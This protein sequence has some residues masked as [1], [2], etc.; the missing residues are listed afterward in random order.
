VLKLSTTQT[1]HAY[2]VPAIV[3][4]PHAAG[5]P[6]AQPLGPPLPDRPPLDQLIDRLAQ[7]GAINT[8][9]SNQ[10]LCR[11]LSAA[12][13]RP[14]EHIIVNSIESQPPLAA[15]RAQLAEQPQAVLDAAQMLFD[16][17]GAR[18]LWLTVQS[19]AAS[20]L[21]RL[22]PLC[23]RRPV[24]L[25]PLPPKY[26]QEC[27]ILLT[28]STIGLT[29][30]ADRRAIES[31]ILILDV[32]TALAVHRAA[33]LALPDTER[34]ITIAGDAARSPGCYRIPTGISLADLINRVG[35]QGSLHRVVV[36]SPMTGQSVTDLSTVVSRT[37]AA[38]LLVSDAPQPRPIAC[39]RC[40]QCIDHCPVRLDPRSLLAMAET[41][42][43]DLPAGGAGPCLECGT[44]SLVCPSNLPL[45]QAVQRLKA[46]SD[47]DFWQDGLGK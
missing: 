34:V 26:P 22:A 7:A 4:E 21:T 19:S 15:Q 25:T 29:Q 12:R 1:V 23:R 36:G 38:V 47:L 41:A 13:D 17:L 40:G 6:E 42:Q 10:S 9:H 35:L 18:R 44:C 45:L 5:Q 30:P 27:D 14:V 33:K 20:L 32:A 11:Q 39:V 37:A 16:A 24:R 8:A 2:D 28:K 43:P 31:G 3:I 46:T